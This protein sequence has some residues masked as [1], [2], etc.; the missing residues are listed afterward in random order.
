MN[1]DKPEYGKQYRLTGGTGTP[2]ISNGNTWAESE[3]K[4]ATGCPSWHHF[5]N[6]YRQVHGSNEDLDK[7]FIRNMREPELQRAIGSM[8]SLLNAEKFDLTD[9]QTNI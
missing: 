4:D 9:K 2:A 5:V 8:K 6:L 7:G 1:Q 3:V